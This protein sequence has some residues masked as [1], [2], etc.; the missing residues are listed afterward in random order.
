MTSSRPTERTLLLMLALVAAACGG[1][2]E[3][4]HEPLPE[5]PDVVPPAAVADDAP[6]V[7]LATSVG[8]IVIALYGEAAP[9]STE[10][11]LRY[12]NE[13]FYDGTIFHRVEPPGAVPVIQGGGLTAD[14]EEKPTHAPVQSEAGNGLS[15]TRGTIAMARLGDPDSATAQF[16]INYLDAPFLD[17][18]PG[19]DG[20]AV[21]GVVVDGMDVVDR[22]TMVPVR[23]VPGTGLNRVPMV[24][25][26]IE[27]ATRE[28]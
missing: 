27:R 9:G 2:D 18:A 14:L 7:R 23:A 4:L 3:W 6:R 8:D 13:G 19:R 11:F 20:Y 10:N 1:R 22:I 5:R 28:R 15:N 16:Y 12:V 24:D 25:V 26:V 21:F 17:R